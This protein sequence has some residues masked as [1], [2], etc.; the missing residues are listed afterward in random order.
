MKRNIPLILLLS[1][2][3]AT[4]IYFLMP[5]LFPG[6]GELPAVPENQRQGARTSRGDSREFVPAARAATPAVVHVKTVYSTAGTSSNSLYGIYGPPQGSAPA[7][8][9]GSGVVI[10]A[11]GYIATN[12]HV[13]E[14]ASGIEVILPD[15]R[16]FKASL[17][18]RD[19]GTDLALLKVAGSGLPVVRL[20]NS[21]KVQVGEWVLAIGYPYSLNTTVTAGIVSAKGRS[22][23]IL[24]RQ[25]SF[26]ERAAP[27]PVESFIQTDAAI[28]PGNSGGALVNG[29]GELIGI[30]AAIASM[31]GSYAGYGFAIPVNLARKILEDLKKYGEVRRGYLGVTF[32]TPLT[33]Q[34]Y[35]RQQG[36]DPGSVKGVY[37]TG[38][39]KGS[40]GQE[41]GLKAGDIVQ[42]IDEAPLS[43]SAEFSERIA[44]HQPG[45]KVQLTVLRAG[46]PQNLTAT[47]KGEAAP[48]QENRLHS[49][50]E[51]YAT[52][53]AAFAPVPAELKQYHKIRSGILVTDVRPGGFFDQVGVT[54]GTILILINGRPVNSPQDIDRALATA[55]G[56]RIQVE[57]IARDGSW[58]MFTFS[59]AA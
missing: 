50:E 56:G 19:P 1:A 38:V 34:Q 36:I 4:G 14:N 9:S 10:S 43:S 27:S 32:P 21:D 58:I 57:G 54:A 16:V 40:A 39:Q 18:G 5:Q 12:N 30:N 53:G 42:R 3:V 22:I 45:D 6:H 46:K 15:K 41:A 51:I 44:R 48:G 47:L 55:E 2:A 13:I 8:G 35:F 11:D 7:A 17:V 20:G 33:E 49:L 52:L 26:P 31:T 29:E 24:D 23:G 59:L 25:G 28:N 37:I